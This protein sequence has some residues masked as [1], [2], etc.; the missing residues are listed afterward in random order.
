M[1]ARRA[2]IDKPKA[3]TEPSDQRLEIDTEDLQTH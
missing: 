3:E 1:D 2:R